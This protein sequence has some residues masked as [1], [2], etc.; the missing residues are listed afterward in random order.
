METPHHPSSR[1]GSRIKAAGASSTGEP[2][3]IDPTHHSGTGPAGV[4][5]TLRFAYRPMWTP[6]RNLI[7]AYVCVPMAPAA[8]GASAIVEVET[9]RSADAHDVVQLDFKVLVHML[10]ELYAMARENR[11]VLVTMPVHFATMELSVH[12]QI[13][14]DTLA[15]AV[16]PS[17]AKRLII[18]LID[19]PD[20]LQQKRLVE[21]ITPLRPYCRALMGRVRIDTTD[22]AMLEVPG[23]LSIGCEVAECGD[24][25]HLV[26]R[27][28]ERFARVSEKS[29]LG[30]HVRGVHTHSL[31]A[32]A[33]GAGFRFID[34]DAVSPL[35]SRPHKTQKFSLRDAYRPLAGAFAAP[36]PARVTG[37]R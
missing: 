15:D 30:T 22:F 14:A 23:I 12:H 32:A 2:S 16:T 18:E 10:G 28:M 26:M 5:D 9:K 1:P 34:G 11:H 31:L 7:S 36:R 24:S 13:F 27:L 4:I 25:E 33:V 6:A 20:D 21:L 35:V 19:I 8:N 17:M 3:G 29:G 37:A